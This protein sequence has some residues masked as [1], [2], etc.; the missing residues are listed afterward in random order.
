MTN[1]EA[2]LDETTVLIPAAGPVPEGLLSL[3]NI[4]CT[5]QI[6]VAGRPVIYWTLTYLRK[7]G[8]RKFV[9]AVPKR[10][11]FVEDFVECTVGRDCQF[12]LVSPTKPHGKLGDTVSLLLQQTK[13]RAAL[14]V[15]GDTYFQFSDPTILAANEPFVLTAPVV[16][17]YRW[18][19]AETTPDGHVARFKDKVPNLQGTLEALIGVYFFPDIEVPRCVIAEVA[20]KMERID[21]TAVLDGV[22]AQSS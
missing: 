8:F 17:S 20:G 12:A 7:L 1:L 5:A 11:L 13:T 4:A 15:L 3:S 9:M 22:R 21:F 10:G 6:P 19:I 14:V 18:N 2:V 16:E